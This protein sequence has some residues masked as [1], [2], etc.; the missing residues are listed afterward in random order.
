MRLAWVFLAFAHLALATGASAKDIPSLYQAQAI[1]TGTG[2][3][4]RQIGFRL[5]LAQVLVKVSGDQRVLTQPG[6]AEAEKHAGDFVAEFR[7][8]DRMEG[9]PVHDE[10]GTHDRP[11]DL[12]CIYAPATLDPLLASLG[13]KPWLAARPKLEVFLAVENA[14]GRFVLAADG[15]DS[16]YMKDSFE[17]AAIPLAMEIVVPSRTVFSTEKL[18]FPALEAA[19]MKLL[20]RLAKQAGADQALAGSIV[21]SDGELGWIC[22]WRL[23]SAGQT[24]EW[25]VRGVSFDEAFRVAMRG[26]AQILSGNGEP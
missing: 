4:N 9:I 11:H 13:T 24:H 22:D 26:A 7:Y 3:E 25:Q 8:R 6:F 19:D 5:C 1:V 17:A 10:Q 16:P 14:K 23:T 12:T 21:W 18:D 20:D 15:D 2:N